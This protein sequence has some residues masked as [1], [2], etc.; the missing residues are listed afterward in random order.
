MPQTTSERYVKK[1]KET[2]EVTE[3][4][5][6]EAYLKYIKDRLF[7]LTTIE[8]RCLAYQLAVKNAKAHNFNTDMEIAGA[9]WI[10][11]FLKG[12]QNLSFLNLK[13][14][15]QLEKWDSTKRPYNQNNFT[16]ADFISAK[17]TNIENIA[18]SSN[19]E[20]QRVSEAEG[21]K[22]EAVR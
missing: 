20:Q 4:D 7:G 12:H 9:D 6:I 18:D 21:L 15:Q 22:S 17:T 8:L 3:E 2:D 16:D 11:S 13:P 14:H 10:K 1:M 19:V 5:E